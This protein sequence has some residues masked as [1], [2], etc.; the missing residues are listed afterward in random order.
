MRV[1]CACVRS[2]VVWCVARVQCRCM[3]VRCARCASEG[4][5]QS[6]AAQLSSAQATGS[7][8]SGLARSLA[9]AAATERERHLATH[10]GKRKK[11]KETLG[12][13]TLD[14]SHVQPFPSRNHRCRC[15]CGCHCRAARSPRLPDSPT[16]A[17][18]R[19]TRHAPDSK[20]QERCD[21]KRKRMDNSAMNK[22]RSRRRDQP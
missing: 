9:R 15:H 8:Q 1:G 12:N 21:G 18:Q 4:A 16:R 2:F 17:K 13:N 7:T 11:K 20:K 19:K 6:R 14:A 22:K 3:R 5:E 10:R